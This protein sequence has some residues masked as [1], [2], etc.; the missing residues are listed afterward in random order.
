M[1]GAT[2]LIRR[3]CCCGPCSTCGHNDAG[4][5]IEQADAD[6]SGGC[7][8]HPDDW[9]GSFYDYCIVGDTYEFDNFYSYVDWCRWRWTSKN[10]SHHEVCSGYFST[11]P[12]TLEL[13]Y[14]RTEGQFTYCRLKFGVGCD[15]Y[16]TDDPADISVTCGADGQLTGS[17]SLTAAD[18]GSWDDKCV[19]CPAVTVT[20]G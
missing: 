8:E 5:D 19:G 12:V 11:G 6:V 14:S 1:S 10:L 17:A 15:A 3:E 7:T 16:D 2:F 9:E 20:F 18:N 4:N 13:T